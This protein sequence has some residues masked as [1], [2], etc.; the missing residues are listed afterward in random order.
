MR[1][2]MHLQGSFLTKGLRAIMAGEWS[3]SKQLAVEAFKFF[4]PL[5]RVTSLVRL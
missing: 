1:S 2:C 3:K 5:A 4:L